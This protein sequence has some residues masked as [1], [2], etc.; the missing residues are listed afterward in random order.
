MYAITKP[1][2]VKLQ[3]F[4]EIQDKP[5][6]RFLILPKESKAPSS[7]PES[8]RLFYDFARSLRDGK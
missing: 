4:F 1:D 5:Q 7:L 2:A 8:A 3:Y 6:L